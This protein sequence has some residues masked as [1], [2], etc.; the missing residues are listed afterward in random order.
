LM[1]RDVIAIGFAIGLFLFLFLGIPIAAAILVLSVIGIMLVVNIDPATALATAFHGQ[2]TN[3]GVTALPLFVLMGELLSRAKIAQKLFDAFAV[4]VGRMPGG[5]I[6]VNVF[7][8]TLRSEST[9]LNSSHVKIS[10]AVF[11]LKK[12]KSKR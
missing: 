4:L 9:R 7:A 12:K 10:Y 1:D 8:S 6:Q 11:C 2:M 5:L 3:W